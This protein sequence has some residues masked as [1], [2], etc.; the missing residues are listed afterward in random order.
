[1][2]SLILLAA[3]AVVGGGGHTGWG[4]CDREDREA[5]L[6]GALHQEVHDTLYEAQVYGRRGRCVAVG[7]SDTEPL[8]DPPKRVM[9]R[10]NKVVRS[11]VVPATK[12]GRCKQPLLTWVA[13]PSCNGRDAY[14]RTR[15]NDHCPLAFHRTGS[16]WELRPPG[17]CE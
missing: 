3:L 10:L 12:A 7:L 13:E 4:T 11:H 5:L 9:L 16:Q 1:M 15:T 6:V 8:I 2:L 14:V 17:A